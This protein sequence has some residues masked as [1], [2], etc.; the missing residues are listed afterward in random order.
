MNIINNRMLKSAIS[1]IIISNNKTECEIYNNKY[2]ATSCGVTALVINKILIHGNAKYKDS[3]YI[4]EIKNH[5]ELQKILE[6]NDEGFFNI[7]MDCVLTYNSNIIK[8]QIDNH[9]MVIQKTSKN[10]YVIYQS[11]INYYS[12]NE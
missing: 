12:L 5:K 2:L 8:N 10:R 11:F 6:N 9:A 7:G 3:L 4:T 1:L